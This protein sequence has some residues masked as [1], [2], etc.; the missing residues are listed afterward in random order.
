VSPP[1]RSTLPANRPTEWGSRAA[2]IYSDP[3]EERYRQ[4]D[5]LIRDGGA[6]TRLA[7]WLRAV[8]ERF[9]AP[10]DVLDLGCGTG[11]H[12]HVLTRAR[13]LVGIDV[14]RP[15]LDR[16]QHPV[17]D[18]GRAA[19]WLTLIEGDFLTYEFEPG[20]FD[21]VY[22]I[23][24]VGE[25]SPFDEAL[26]AR[27]RRWLKPGGRLA[28]TTVHPLSASVPRTLGRRIGEWMLPIAR[29]APRRALR[30]RLMRAGL[31]AD[32]ERVNDVLAVAGFSVESMELFQSDV[33]LHVLTV[34]GALS[35][36]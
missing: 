5:E 35:H 28:F 9:P 14:S 16:A 21:L 36:V 18:P 22:S 8:S 25:H 1:T 13:R 24:V 2:A 27:V 19:G 15:M 31:Y 4:H 32:E 26:A 30:S 23:G 12:F 34:A 3:Y 17:G 6:V 11:R 29:G 33:H 20:E 10:P 7:S